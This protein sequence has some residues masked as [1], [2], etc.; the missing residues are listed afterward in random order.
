VDLD[1]LS[2]VG[3]GTGMG[4]V[5]LNIRRVN[6]VDDEIFGK[7]EKD[8]IASAPLATDAEFLR[9]VSIDLTGRIPDASEVAAFAADPAG[10]KRIRKIDQLLASDA[11]VDRWALYFDDLY[12][13]TFNADSGK[14]GFGGRNAFHA[15]FV[16]SL[17]SKKPYDVMARDLITATGDSG[18]VGP[19]NF[20]ARNIQTNGPRSGQDTFDNLAASVGEA[21]LGSNALFCASCHNG[22]G[23]MDLINI[24]GSKFS[25]Q[26]FW[27][28]AAFWA[29]TQMPRQGTQFGAYTY[30][31]ADN[32]R[33]PDYQLNTT[34]GNKTP[35]DGTWTTPQG[36]TVITPKY[37][38]SGPDPAAGTRPTPQQ[39]ENYRA[40]LARMVTGDPQFARAT[41]NYLWQE[42]FT[43]GIVEPANSFD[44]ARQ[45][46]ANPPPAPW[47][48]QP[49]HP[50]LLTRLGQ[51]LQSSG[52]DLRSILRTIT[53]SSAYQLSSFYPGTWSDG[54]APY[55]ARHF[56][57]RLG[58]EML[59]DAVTKA[60]GVTYPMTV[61]G[62]TNPVSW[63][64]QLPDVTEPANAPRGQPAP[65]NARAIR[66]FLDTFLRGDRDTN[67]RSYEMSISQALAAM[68]DSTVV[69][70]RVR[71]ATS[72]STVNKLIAA[73]ATPSTIIYTLYAT[74]LS[75]YP[76]TS[77]YATALDLYGTPGA[78]K[79]TVTEDLQWA[80]LNKLDFIL[81]Y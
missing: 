11:F 48:L 25:R 38:S 3:S 33:A 59:Y 70:T 80:L 77:E 76:T 14:L 69:T 55:F 63:A 20:P 2:T 52:Y 79:T 29:K 31:V 62:Y 26:M 1:E 72:G 67:F 58:A 44:F 45:D 57:R 54:Y 5:R 35:R 75:R 42:L 73:N 65:A 4:G 30:A 23:H 6:F 8:G 50:E 12:R 78:S 41:V 34:T 56:V 10:D 21:F 47:T 53:S 37:L 27:E 13:N 28:M 40:A 66:A 71:N 15:Y 51:E 9:R 24:W 49:T 22:A 43:V 32:T 68:N 39:G 60:T 74:T 46:P 16:D 18:L 17:R 81:N 61:N 19:S 7:M 64:V 36:L